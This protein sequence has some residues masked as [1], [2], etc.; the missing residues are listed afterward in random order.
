MQSGEHLPS[1][2]FRKG[3]VIPVILVSLLTVGMYSPRAA[4]DPVPEACFS[5][6]SGTGMITGYDSGSPSCILDVGIPA[7]ISGTAV[8]SIGDWVFYG[9]GLTGVELPNSLV[10]IGDGAFGD[11]NLSSIVIPNSVTTIGAQAFT[12]NQIIN[13]TLGAAVA[14]IGDGAFLNNQL[15]SLVIPASVTQIDGNAFGYNSLLTIRILGSPDIPDMSTFNANGND[16]ASS[17]VTVGTEPWASW[18]QANAAFVKVY[19]SDSL[20]TDS[21]IPSG[22]MDTYVTGALLKNPARYTVEYK[23]TKGETIAPSRTVINH[24]QAVMT[25]RYE[26]FIDDSDPLNPTV[27]GS[28]FYRIGESVTV[29]PQ[30]ISG[31]ATPDSQ[32]ITLGEDTVVTFVYAAN[33]SPEV[34]AET[35]SSMQNT[36]LAAC[37]F[38]LTGVAA[39][40]FRRS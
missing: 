13:L 33:S 10:S 2:D 24:D 32:T 30:M 4:A 34:L 20:F 12:D 21:F 22:Y 40:R 27:D 25:Y 11:N 28:S 17:P 38:I 31:Y 3:L 36:L 39:L 29:S 35:G 6:D 26:P 16:I 37:T 19:T 15:T 5:F 1:R 23:N 14:T 18:Q 9:L 8:T 7:T